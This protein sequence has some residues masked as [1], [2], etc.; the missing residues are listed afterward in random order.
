MRYVVPICLALVGLLHLM[1]LAGVLGAERLQ[2]LYGIAL[3][4]PD[5]I[6]LLRHRA[7]LFGLLGGFLVLAAFRPAL[8]LAALLIGLASVASFLWLAWPGQDYTPAIR[9]VFAADVAALG[10]LVVGV[11]VHFARRR[12]LPSREG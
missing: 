1:P 11:L 8:H 4:S 5:L 7:V 6:L 12:A 2:A 3:D 10:L 9:Q